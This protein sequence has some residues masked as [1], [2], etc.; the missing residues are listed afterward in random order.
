MQGGFDNFS[1]LYN[2]NFS[3]TLVKDWDI[4]QL[5]NEQTILQL[6]HKEYLNDATTFNWVGKKLT[7]VWEGKEVDLLKYE[8]R[9]NFGCYKM[10]YSSEQGCQP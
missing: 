10:G 6:I 9:F 1:G 8:S 3:G 7:S 4:N 2:G 5:K